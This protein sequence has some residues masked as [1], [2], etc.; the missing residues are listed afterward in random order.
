VRFEEV[1][2]QM[3]F[4]QC[5]SPVHL[6]DTLLCVLNANQAMLFGEANALVTII[7]TQMNHLLT[8]CSNS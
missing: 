8:T 2:V 5:T 4:A 1:V 3:G 7:F 6:I